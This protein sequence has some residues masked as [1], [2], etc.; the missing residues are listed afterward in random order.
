M[1]AK[2]GLAKD[3]LAGHETHP[4]CHLHCCAITP[5]R[6]AQ[7]A[8]DARSRTNWASVSPVRPAH[9]GKK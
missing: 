8:T 4:L 6:G 3:C 2:K 9:G 7:I 1:A 5:E